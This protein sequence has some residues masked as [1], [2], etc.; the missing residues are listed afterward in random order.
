MPFLPL[1]TSF[2]ENWLGSTTDIL[3]I[4]IS[5]LF[6]VTTCILYWQK[7][8]NYSLCALGPVAGISVAYYTFFSAIIPLSQEML[9][10]GWISCLLLLLTGIIILR[11]FRRSDAL[12]DN[13]AAAT[14]IFIIMLVC[15][16]VALVGVNTPQVMI[17]DEVTHFYMLK[18]QSVDLSTINFFSYIPT[19]YG[20]IDIRRYPHSFGWHYLG[21]I[22]YR[23]FGHSIVA[24]QLYQLFFLAQLLVASFLLSRDR[25]NYKSQ[26]T[27]LYLATL[28]SVP[29]TLLF[30]VA[31][32]QDI[33][34]TAQVVTAFLCL[35]KR[36]W[37]MA[38]AFMAFAIFM[39]VTAILF[40]PA[41]FFYLFFLL[42][43]N[44]Q[45]QKVV[46]HFVC[47]IMIVLG[48]TWCLGRAINIYA[49]SSFYPQ[50]KVEKIWAVAKSKIEILINRDK[51]PIVDQYERVLQLEKKDKYAGKKTV[52]NK[53]VVIANHPGDL[54][55]KKNFLLYGGGVL[56]VV[57]VLGALSQSLY[58]WRRLLK[59]KTTSAS[60]WWL[61]AVGGS[62]LL[63]TA[64]FCHS[65]P[66]ARF[67][68][69]ALPFIL[70]PLS[71]KVARMP[72]AKYVIAVVLSCSLLQSGMVLAKVY[73]LRDISMETR[74]AIDYLRKN[75]PDPP[76]IFM[77]PEG[78]YRYFPVAH[79]W[80]FGYRL[81][82]FWRADNKKRIQMLRDN[83][84]GAIVIKKY[85]VSPVDDK[86]TN[87]GVYPDYFV[88]SL[89]DDPRFIRVFDNQ[90]ISIY[91]WRETVYQ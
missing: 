47:S 67:F 73:T 85:L 74:S 77:Y 34:M 15:F 37:I 89:K 76:K 84:V 41:F 1:I 49:L 14:S 17:G 30:S 42:C 72:K 11:F 51:H 58:F 23:L 81:R 79:E 60:S 63:L 59:I 91:T 69:P 9:L 33:P 75:L 86:I 62:Y 38:S 3:I 90:D 24:V 35:R 54:R 52:E 39:K 55:I 71:E 10:R 21:A 43:K 44:Q 25:N 40:F 45:W 80:Y 56:W 31:F 83:G 18:R 13:I 26:A 36:R 50:R 64:Y 19:E 48:A 29:V 53:P 78:N 61:W 22:V 46:L 4:Y 27:G 28:G 32:Y 7:R 82:Q 2:I 57:V 12:Y 87:L 20:D 16:G 5:I 68:F 66:D 70:L 6:T 65:S 8:V 88:R